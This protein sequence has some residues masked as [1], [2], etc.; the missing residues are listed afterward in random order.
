MIMAEVFSQMHNGYI[1]T[2]RIRNVIT[3]GQPYAGLQLMADGG[4]YGCASIV[5]RHGSTLGPQ[6]KPHS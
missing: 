4:T 2:A 6:L 1:I 3:D 5:L